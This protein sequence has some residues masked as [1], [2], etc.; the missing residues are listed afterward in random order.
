[1]SLY[2]SFSASSAVED[3]ASILRYINVLFYSTVH[4][5]VSLRLCHMMELMR[6]FHW[7]YLSVTMDFFEGWEQYLQSCLG[8]IVVSQLV[9]VDPQNIKHV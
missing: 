6:L 4:K 1:M 3:V 8:S 5:I 2:F 7:S 9:A